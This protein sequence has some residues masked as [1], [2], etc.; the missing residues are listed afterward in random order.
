M[1]EVNRRIA[2]PAV[3]ATVRFSA[4]C[5]FLDTR[6]EGARTGHGFANLLAPRRL[7]RIAGPARALARFVAIES[8]P[9]GAIE[10]RNGHRRFVDGVNEAMS[11]CNV[12]RVIGRLVTDDGFRRRFTQDPAGTMRE[13]VAEGLELNGC[14]RRALEAIDPEPLNRFVE[15]LHPCIQKVE[16]LGGNT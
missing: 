14:E 6:E 4:G 7:W 1:S 10:C 2:P 5:R 15:S 12:E 3:A 8:G 13:L 16:L 9:A 11:Q